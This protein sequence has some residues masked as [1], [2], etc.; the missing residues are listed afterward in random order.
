LL[1]R[2]SSYSA[3]AG[4]FFAAS[5]LAAIPH[6]LAQNVPPSGP[7]TDSAG[8]RL[9][10][11]PKTSAILKSISPDF[12]DYLLKW[13]ARDM[14]VQIDLMVVS[15][16]DFAPEMLHGSPVKSK[17]PYILD[18]SSQ[19]PDFP[20]E[21]IAQGHLSG[22]LIS[23][24]LAQSP[25]GFP[26]PPQG[27]GDRQ[28]L[29]C[30]VIIPDVEEVTARDLQEKIASLSELPDV[31]IPG[32]IY[33]WTAFISAHEVR[34]CHHSFADL[35]PTIGLEFEI[36]ADN[37]MIDTFRADGDDLFPGSPAFVEIPLAHIALRS[38]KPVLESNANHITAAT[39]KRGTEDDVISPTGHEMIKAQRRLYQSII[40]EGFDLEGLTDRMTTQQ[41][42]R[43]ARSLN[44]KNIYIR[45]SIEERFL[46]RFIWSA[47]NYF[48]D[49]FGLGSKKVEVANR[50]AIPAP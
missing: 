27:S 12:H 40:Q 9:F 19:F 30:A 33:E 37:S 4:A 11:S 13:A 47:E 46:N 10:V 6:S 35:R 28:R 39:L 31:R 21:R 26:L 15:S 50:P 23:S 1:L 38:L 45:G 5:F 2:R 44:S 18:L 41:A 43:A 8:S 7:Y 24:A 49:F 42:Y 25:H 16:R 48:R 22:L 3:L 17:D 36:D 32:N 29:A 34:H 14:G 20:L